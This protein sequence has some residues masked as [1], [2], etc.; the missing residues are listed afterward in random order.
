MGPRR[1][2]LEGLADRFSFRVLGIARPAGGLPLHGLG[3]G[4][5]QKDGLDRRRVGEPPVLRL[6]V[7]A[8]SRLLVFGHVFVLRLGV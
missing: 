3:A 6:E 1:A 4:H 8:G 2:E 7:V 5:H